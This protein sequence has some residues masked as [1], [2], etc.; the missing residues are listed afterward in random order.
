MIW[1]I[2]CWQ[3]RTVH[4]VYVISP[5]YARRR[6]DVANNLF[7][8]DARILVII[9]FKEKKFFVSACSTNLK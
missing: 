1:Q 8:E 5:N 3:H 2:N 7:A 4:T 9:V 6:C